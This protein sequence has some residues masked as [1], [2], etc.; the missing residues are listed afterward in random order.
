MKDHVR[1][2]FGVVN[3]LNKYGKLETLTN[4]FIKV[5]PTFS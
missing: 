2:K 1:N 4:K 5:G 3:S